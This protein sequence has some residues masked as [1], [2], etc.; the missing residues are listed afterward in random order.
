MD[1]LGGNTPSINGW[2]L[3][4]TPMT[5][6]SWPVW[7]VILE[8][9]YSAVEILTWLQLRSPCFPEKLGRFQKD[10]HHPTSNVGERLAN[11]GFNRP[12]IL[13]P[14]VIQHFAMERS[15]IFHGENPLFLWPFS[16]A[17]FVHQRVIPNDR[18]RT[19]E[20]PK[21]DFL[22][23]RLARTLFGQKLR[24]GLAHEKAFRLGREV[25]LNP[26]V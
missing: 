17:I 4:G 11:D 13:Y 2:K 14:L 23:D 6:F 19:S 22:L 5:Q 9:S 21:L 3:G 15:T 8:P 1:D 7:T 25:G 24:P 26:Y 16:I 12:N 20:S 18:Q 10:V